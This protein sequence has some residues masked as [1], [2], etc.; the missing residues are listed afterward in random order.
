MKETTPTPRITLLDLADV[1]DPSFL[2]YF[3]EDPTE[4]IEHIL[5]SFEK[6]CQWRSTKEC[7]LN[8][9]TRLVHQKQN[10]SKI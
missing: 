4:D 5:R 2:V 1:D 3:K 8:P 6:F 7:V 9:T 10:R